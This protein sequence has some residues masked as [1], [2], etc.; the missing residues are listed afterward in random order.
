MSLAMNWSPP[1]N[2]LHH[3]RILVPKIISHKP[4]IADASPED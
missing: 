1:I 3:L 2:H 4:I